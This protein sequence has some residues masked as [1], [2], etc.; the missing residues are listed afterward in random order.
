MKKIVIGATALA[1]AVLMAVAEQPR[2]QDQFNASV[3]KGLAWLVSV[4]GADGGW[5]QDG[6]NTSSIRRGERLESQ[7][8]DVA[9]TAVALMA[10]TR[11][12]HTPDRGI[13]REPVRRGLEFLLTSIERA[14]QDTLAVTDVRD[15]QIQRKLGPYIDTFFSSMLLSELDGKVQ[16]PQLS[17][18]IHAALGKTVAKIQA[19]Q[20]RDGSWNQAGGWAPVLGT[21]MAS[22]SLAVAKEKGIAVDAAVMARVDEYTR[23]AGRGGSNNAAASPVAVYQGAQMLE[24]LSR[25]ES[26]RRKNQG[27]IGEIQSKLAD[28]SY[29]AGFGSMGGEEYFSY[30]NISDSLKRTGGKEWTNWNAK[31]KESLLSAQNDDGTWAGH[32]CITGRVAVTSAAIPTMVAERNESVRRPFAGLPNK[33]FA[34][35]SRGMRQ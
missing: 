34:L 9:N 25:T 23:Q 8:N 12:G 28:S 1:A 17:R 35:H 24:Q 29:I 13:Y 11:N 16:Q 22:R 2:S 30:L 31:I 18:R 20:G 14:P 26:D 15:T 5:G 4:Q 19:N 3:E 7:G 32:H 10:L 27:Q 21:S 6:G 33:G